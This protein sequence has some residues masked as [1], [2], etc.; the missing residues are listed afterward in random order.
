ISVAVKRGP[1]Q[2]RLSSVACVRIRVSPAS[3]SLIVGGSMAA[4]RTRGRNVGGAWFSRNMKAEALVE[5]VDFDPD[6]DPSALDRALTR[7]LAEEAERSTAAARIDRVI[8]L[9]RQQARLAAREHR[10]LAELWQLT[11]SE[12]PA[13][14]TPTE[15]D[16]AWRS[17]VAELAV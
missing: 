11:Q 2:F 13:N 8:S 15:T 9:R 5:P 4:Q 17:L 10:E 16:H 14:A 6:L 1:N 7:I 12:L 3:S